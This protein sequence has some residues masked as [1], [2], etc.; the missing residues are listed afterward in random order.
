[1]SKGVKEKCRAA[2]CYTYSPLNLHAFSLYSVTPLPLYSP[3]KTNDMKIV[4]D[5]KIPYIRET[6]ERLAD[7][8][9]YK[10]GTEIGP[11]DVRDADALIVRTRTR[12]DAAL[13]EG[14]SVRFVATATIGF[15][16]IDA[17]Y[18]RRAGIEWMSCPGC[19]A[20]SVAQYV[21]SVLLLLRR[22]RGAQLGGMTIGIVGCGHVGSR[23]KAVAEEYGMRTLVCDPPRQE[24]GDGGTF[25]SLADIARESDIVTFHTPLTAGGP[26]PTRHMASAE[27]FDSLGR[28]P[29]II[30]TSRGEV[31]DTGALL[32]ALIYNKVA[33]AVI[34]TWEGEPHVSLPLLR[35]AWIATPHI[36]GYSAD[37]KANADNMVIAGLCRHFGLP[38]PPPIVPP[39]LPQGF[40]DGYAGDDLYLRLYNPLDD[41]AR[42]KAAPERFEELRGNYPLRREKA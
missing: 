23:V 29:L 5:D 12:C 11:A 42:L 2:L 34:D 17:D 19:N 4:I 37:G 8:V 14:S 21:M 24:R 28:R 39:E 3:I 9:V 13:L 41:S 16:H 35:R 40:A 36:A 1:M 33:D 25:V 22:D 38:L 32:D 31:V 10:K 6:A 15:D 30:N 20:A 26:H 7:C 18:M 27:F